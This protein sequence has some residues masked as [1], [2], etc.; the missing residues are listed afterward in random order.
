M[1]T[2]CVSALAALVPLVASAQEDPSNLP[3]DDGI[4]VELPAAERI[5]YPPAS[6]SL[7]SSGPVIWQEDFERDGHSFL[8]LEFSEVAAQPGTSFEVVIRDYRAERMFV[9]GPDQFAGG[10][11]WT[12]IIPGDIAVVEVRASAPPPGLKFAIR[13]AV[14]EQEGQKMLSV[15]GDP[16]FEPAYRLPEPDLAV[17][18]AVGKVHF[19]KGGKA[20]S[21]TG[22]LISDDLLLTNEHCVNSQIICNQTV[23]LFGYQRKDDGTFLHGAQYACSEYRASQYDR[24]FSL[25]RLKDRPGSDARWQALRLCD[26]EVSTG[27]PLFIVQHPSGRPKEFV[28][29]CHVAKTPA[30]GRKNVVELVDF[31]HDCDTERGSS[32]S[33]VLDAHRDVVG[34]HHLGKTT[35]EYREVNRAVRMHEVLPLLG[36]TAQCSPVQ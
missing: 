31:S 20:S 27:E 18:S 26:R 7:P 23:V 3:L 21:C 34:L 30:D 29:D 16:D 9:Y 22:F 12:G 28:K 8:R 19:I 25:L 11:F 1:R 35:G 13:R 10:P 14:L 17:A 36:L 2:A 4:V 24:D 5:V 33:P 15:I 32:G 6:S